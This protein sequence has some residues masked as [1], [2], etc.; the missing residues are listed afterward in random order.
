MNESNSDLSDRAPTKLRNPGF[1]IRVFTGDQGLRSG[2]RLFL[3]VI[4]VVL[5]LW[6]ASVL[7]RAFFGPPLQTATPGRTI[8]A[9]I[10]MLIAAI[11]PALVAARLENRPWASYGLPFRFAEAGRF[12][13]GLLV[14]FAALSGLLFLIHLFHGFYLGGIAIHGSTLVR[15]AALWAIAFLLVGLAEEFLFR[16]Y[17]LYTL[18]TGIGFWPAGI[19]LCVLFGGLH[20]LNG[21]EDWLGGI[22]T[23]ANALVF[24]FSLWR[25][26]N[27][28]FAMGMHASWDWG[29][30]FF[31][32]VP[33][34]GVA[35]VG[36]LFSP[37]FAGSK[38]ITGGSVGPEGSVLVFVVIAALFLVIHLL[39]PKRQWQS[40]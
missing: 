12:L 18:A 24:V 6:A 37:R 5:L 20:L 26:G 29:E 28:W 4:A 3:Y 1:M 34:S 21:G 10:A 39:Y 22:A 33:D 7:L 8:A 38:W 19:A 17:S 31:F 32:G 2:W 35:S 27:L 30:S 40:E 13:V 15:Y 9:E 16:G 23:A 25:T 14:G 36:T 11:A